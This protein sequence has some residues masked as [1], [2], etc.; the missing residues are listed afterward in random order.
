MG[1]Q[2]GRHLQLRATALWEVREVKKLFF[3]AVQGPVAAG[4]AVGAAEAASG[5]RREQWAPSANRCAGTAWP[6]VGLLLPSPNSLERTLSDDTAAEDSWVPPEEARAWWFPP[7]PCQS[8][9]LNTKTF[10][11]RPGSS[12]T[13]LVYSIFRPSSFSWCP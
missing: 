11:T 12:H 3:V 7:L 9:S 5:L 6:L 8:V 10:D 13:Y 2:T 1:T 4:S